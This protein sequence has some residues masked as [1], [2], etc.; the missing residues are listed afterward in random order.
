MRAVNIEYC[1]APPCKVIP[2]D[3][4]FSAMGY[5][6][7]VCRCPL[8]WDMRV[9]CVGV[10]FRWARF[11][12]VCG[13]SYLGIPPHP[14]SCGASLNNVFVVLEIPSEDL[15]FLPLLQRNVRVLYRYT[16]FLHHLYTT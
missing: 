11:R 14:H 7:G 5:A 6:G 10:R 4:P 12:W 1:P 3:T 13:A 16:W 8:P 9:V 2:W 15:S